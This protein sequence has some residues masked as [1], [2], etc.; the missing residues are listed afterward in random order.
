[1]ASDVWVRRILLA[2][3]PAYACA[4]PMSRG[5]LQIGQPDY[6]LSVQTENDRRLQPEAFASRFPLAATSPRNEK[7]RSK[8]SGLKPSNCISG[9]AFFRNACCV[10]DRGA[11]VPAVPA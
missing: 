11:I 8:H 5:Q 10:Q 3:A 1:M 7:V 2:V 4:R 6:A 9:M